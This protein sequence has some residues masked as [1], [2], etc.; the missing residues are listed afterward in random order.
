MTKPEVGLISRARPITQMK[1]P[2]FATF[3]HSTGKNGGEE[4]EE[5]EEKENFSMLN[6]RMP[7]T[8]TTVPRYL[9]VLRPG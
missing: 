5:E 4:E 6:I 2:H 1:P 8:P 7:R 3:G 9:G